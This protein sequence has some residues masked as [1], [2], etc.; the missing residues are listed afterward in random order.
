MGKKE[1]ISTSQAKEEKSGLSWKKEYVIFIVLP[2]ILIILAPLGGLPYL[3]GRLNFHIFVL[4]MTYPV[5]GIFIICCFIAG[6]IRLIRDLGKRNRMIIMHV[7]EIIIPIVFVVL[8]IIPFF[9]PNESKS[10][11]PGWSF[12]HG[13]MDRIK[14]KEDISAIRDW[15]KTLGKEDYNNFGET[16]F[17]DEWPESLIALRPDHVSVSLSAD[18][19][20]NP[21][22]M[23]T[24]GGGP[25]HWGV[26]IGMENMEMTPSDF[27]PW[28]ESWKL[29]EPGVYFC[30]F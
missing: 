2:I 11:Y 8:F 16:L 23:I 21:Q 6:I 25:F 20:G 12:S 14:S 7:A 5:I 26:I 22:I 29:L 4:C 28:A 19:N 30:T 27:K 15:M 24:W 17:P 10:W 13:L 9:F 1:D 3:C 18:K